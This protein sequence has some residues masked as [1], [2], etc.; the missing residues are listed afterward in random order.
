MGSSNR[1]DA[2]S[3][4][5]VILTVTLAFPF[6]VT[7]ILVCVSVRELPTLL[8][9]TVIPPFRRRKD[10]T[11]LLPLPGTIL[12]PQQLTLKAVVIC[13]VAWILLFARRR[14]LTFRPPSLPM[15]LVE[16]GPT[17]L[18]TVRI[19]NRWALRLQKIISRLLLRYRLTRPCIPLGT[20]VRNTL[21]NFRSF[22]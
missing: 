16:A 20:L 6:T 5:T 1:L 2:T 9:I 14:I 12:V 22:I 8:L 4:I 15:V 18:E 7:S 19:V 21:S 3:A 10:T 13:L 11:H 17:W